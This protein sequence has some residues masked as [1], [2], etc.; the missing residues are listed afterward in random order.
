MDIILLQCYV[1]NDHANHSPRN[2]YGPNV[3]SSLPSWKNQL[4]TEEKV[5]RQAQTATPLVVNARSR[6]L[7]FRET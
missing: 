6:E 2:P 4:Y 1:H 3:Q 7:S 5:S